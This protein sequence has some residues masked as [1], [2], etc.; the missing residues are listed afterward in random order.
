[1]FWYLLF[2]SYS[3]TYD[4]V[5]SVMKIAWYRRG[6]RRLCKKRKNRQ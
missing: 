4:K 1:M 5:A 6:E 2:I 3:V